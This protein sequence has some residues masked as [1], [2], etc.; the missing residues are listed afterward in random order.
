MTFDSLLR[1]RTTTSRLLAA[2]VLDLC[3]GAQLLGGAA[4]GVGFYYDFSL[5]DPLSNEMI[6][7]IEERMHVLIR[8]GTPIK[9]MEMV[10]KSGSELLKHHKQ[11]HR[12]KAARASHHQII[13]IFRMGTMVDYCKE[14]FKEGFPGAFKIQ[15][16]NQIEGDVRIQGTAFEDERDLKFFITFYK[17][18]KH[19]E[20]MTH[21]EKEGLFGREGKSLYWLPKGEALY[22]EILSMIRKKYTEN[23]FQWVKI[24]GDPERFHDV[25]GID[26]FVWNVYE[27][28]PS[29]TNLITTGQSLT[30]KAYI[31]CKEMDREMET[32][33][34]LHFIEGI[35]R[36]MNL[37]YFI[38]RGKQVSVEV[39]DLYGR[40]WPC[41]KIEQHKTHIELS[42]FKS[43]ERLIGLFIE[44][45]NLSKR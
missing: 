28:N 41:F 17:K 44:N 35:S 6:P 36:I 22:Q 39:A 24:S 19:L 43:L 7:H 45:R 5:K 9:R 1:L 10:P 25:S 32:R 33:S 8:Q 18:N 16:I 26:R 38:V 13:Q 21:G 31:Y 37:K 14:P 11:Y 27:N 34:S 15:K 2:A 4:T 3:P 29:T 20:H 42:A 30:N 23:G 40:K 12:A